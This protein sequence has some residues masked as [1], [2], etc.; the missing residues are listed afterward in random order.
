MWEK[1]EL[2]GWSVFS[3]GIG[4]FVGILGGFWYGIQ[5][6]GDATIIQTQE[7]KMIPVLSFSQIEN[8]ILMGTSTAEIRIEISNDSV[9]VT[10]QGSFA[11][12]ITA[13]LPMIQKIPSPQ[14]KNWVASRS[15]KKYYPLDSP[16]A[17]LLTPKNRMFY[18]TEQEAKNDGKEKS[19]K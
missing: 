18:A 3:V 13:I 1:I 17:F 7:K 10:Q 12:P 6:A 14:G 8:G 2:F 19:V 15:G 9:E 11:I 4:F 5:S 16:S